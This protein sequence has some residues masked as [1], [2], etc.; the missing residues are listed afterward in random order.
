MKKENRKE[1]SEDISIIEDDRDESQ[2]IGRK[3]A[4]DKNS[5]CTGNPAGTFGNL[6]SDHGDPGQCMEI[7]RTGRAAAAC[8]DHGR[9]CSLRNAGGCN[10]K[11]H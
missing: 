8:T 5:V 9:R 2:L 1:I 11:R 10:G 7:H 4:E 3:A 6:G